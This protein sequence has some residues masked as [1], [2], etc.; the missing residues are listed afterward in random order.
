MEKEVV[1]KFLK[2]D[3][4]KL[5]RIFLS[6]VLVKILGI[7]GKFNFPRLWCYLIDVGSFQRLAD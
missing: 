5:V 1:M 3:F 7:L 4:E 6:A 2:I